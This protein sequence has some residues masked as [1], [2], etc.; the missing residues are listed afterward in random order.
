MKPLNRMRAHIWI[1]AKAY[2]RQRADGQRNPLA[3]EPL[4][5]GRVIDRVNAVIDAL[6]L[7]AI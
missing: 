4:H 3:R 6:D 1:D 7:Q 5:Q 2:I